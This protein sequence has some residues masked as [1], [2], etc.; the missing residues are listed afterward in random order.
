M[1]V[2]GDWNASLAPRLGYAVETVTS[3]TDARF[4]QWVREAGLSYIPPSS[5]TWT[6]GRRRAVL[7]AFVVRE[8]GSLDLPT[9]V[10]SQDPRHDHRAVLAALMDERIGPIP[11]LEALFA[12]VRLKLEALKE[13]DLRR[14]YVER[15]TEAT[16]H[17]QAA[18]DTA[19]PF[20]RLARIQNVVLQVAK[21]TLATRGG[22]IL[23]MLPRHSAAFQ[24]LAAHV[25]LLQVVHKEIRD[26]RGIVLPASRAMQRLWHRDWEAFP[27]GTAFEALGE[28]AGDAGWSRRAVAELRAHLHRA[29]EELRLRRLRSLEMEA[30]SKKRRQAAI[31]SFWTGG[32][33]RWFLH[34]PSPS[35]H[36]PI[37]HG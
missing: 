23:S 25:R 20:V 7:D 3:A 1:I 35:L 18:R 29:D 26:R 8:A 15:A 36:S 9:C 33:L 27:E 10:E 28:L 37:L 6:D 11:E 4:A 14:T 17:T 22:K 12:P 30:A 34:P 31:D 19:C 32:G 24:R 21:A 16:E 5:H 13:P 2:G